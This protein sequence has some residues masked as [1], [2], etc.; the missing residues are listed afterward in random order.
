MKYSEGD[1][2]YDRNYVSVAT[3]TG[4]SASLKAGTVSQLLVTGLLVGVCGL[5]LR[6]A[7]EPFYSLC[8]FDQVLVP[9]A[10]ASFKEVFPSFSS[11]RPCFTK[12]DQLLVK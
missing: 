12:E 6:R 11:E 9:G 5:F 8:E 2:L 1:L 10:C 3:K 7:L 4:S